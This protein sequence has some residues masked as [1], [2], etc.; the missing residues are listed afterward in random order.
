MSKDLFST[1]PENL[2]SEMQIKSAQNILKTENLY[3]TENIDSER[4]KNFKSHLVKIGTIE[5]K[6]NKT[7]VD[8]LI[9]RVSRNRVILMREN[10]KEIFI[11]S[12]LWL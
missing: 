6:D 1:L 7:S 4:L 9:D 10:D 12:S 3:Y 2:L 11:V 5:I 8:M